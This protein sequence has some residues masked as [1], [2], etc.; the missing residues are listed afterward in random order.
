MNPLRSNLRHLIRE[1]AVLVLAHLL[2]V[3]TMVWMK[4]RRTPGRGPL[5]MP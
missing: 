4:K 2:V 5:P 1:L 3:A